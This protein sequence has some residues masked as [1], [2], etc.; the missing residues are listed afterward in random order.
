MVDKIDSQ[1]PSL[2]NLG[3]DQKMIDAFPAAAIASE[4][5]VDGI[6]ERVDEAIEDRLGEIDEYNYDFIDRN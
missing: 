2:E 5:L 6:H 3:I 4:S 1:I